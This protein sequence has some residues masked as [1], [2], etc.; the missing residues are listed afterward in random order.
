MSI[1]IY[2]HTH[3]HIYKEDLVGTSQR[4]QGTYIMK[5]NRLLLRREILAAN[6][7]N[8]PEHMHVLCAKK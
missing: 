2:I 8:R 6:W 1:Y 3:T 5:T 7:K 4:T